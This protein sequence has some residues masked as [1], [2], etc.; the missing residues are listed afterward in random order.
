MKS[1]LW[2]AIVFLAMS[3][4]IVLGCLY[5]YSTVGEDK[6]PAQKIS[7]VI[8]TYAEPESNPIFLVRAE[9]RCRFYGHAYCASA[10]AQRKSI[11]GLFTTPLQLEKTADNAVF[12]ATYLDSRTRLIKATSD[13][14]QFLDTTPS[15]EAYLFA[16]TSFEEEAGVLV[17]AIVSNLYALQEDA[18]RD[19]DKRGNWMYF[20][21]FLSN[22]IVLALVAVC[23]RRS[24]PNRS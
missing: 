24:P 9:D 16:S 20:F 19:S 3:N 23:A 18:L 7:R 11:T 21:G 13:Y 2:A 15:T 1:K 14:I 4:L 12:Y 22:V 8:S 5:S 6:S 10:A 17:G